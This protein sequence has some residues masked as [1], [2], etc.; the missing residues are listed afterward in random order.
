MTGLWT[1]SDLGCC[2]IHLT[3][4]LINNLGKKNVFIR[5]CRDFF[6]HGVTFC[7]WCWGQSS[8]PDAFIYARLL[9]A[10][11]NLQYYNPV[12]PSHP[13]YETHF[14]LKPAPP[15]GNICGLFETIRDGTI[16]P[17][18]IRFTILPS[19]TILCHFQ[20]HFLTFGFDLIRSR[21]LL[22]IFSHLHSCEIQAFHNR[23]GQINST[24]VQPD[25]PGPRAVI[26]RL[27]VTIG[28]K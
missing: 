4:V 3:L 12:R 5:I 25:L 27:R 1:H 9:K 23:S 14:I 11:L 21:S 18:S 20:T 15:S 19:Q 6:N 26:S 8:V 24:L 10:C 2:E 16:H 22:V 28:G 13:W 7:S 17:D